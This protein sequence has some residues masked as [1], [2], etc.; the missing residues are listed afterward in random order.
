VRIL[1]RYLLA[2]YLTL[3]VS[4]LCVAALVIAIVEMML[5]FEQMFEQ[6][7]GLRGVA[8][9]L[10]LR[11]A[12][13]YLPY[14][15]PFASFGAGFLCLGIP[16]RAHE[17]VA[18]K[19]GGIAPLRIASPLLAAALA[20]SMLT[21]IANE[22]MVLDAT[23]TRV[24]RDADEDGGGLFQARGSF[25]YHRGTFLYNVRE[26]DRASR[27]LRGVSVFERD[28]A[29]QL[30]RRLEAESAHISED[31]RWHLRNAT[32]RTFDTDDPTAAPRTEHLPE[33]VLA[34]GTQRNL[35]LLD[36][37][38]STLSLFRLREYIRAVKDDG[39]DSTRY[40]AMFHERLADPVSVLLFTLLGI[41]LGLAVEQSRSL[42]VAG[43]QGIALLGLFYAVKTLTS[44]LA[45]SGVTAAVPGPW[46]VV[47]AFGGYAAWRIA[48][49]PS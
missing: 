22:T 34:V 37:D 17:L 32:V 38:A 6:G 29:G 5:N 4:I 12:T 24:G 1:S 16:A 40:R 41:P 28:G 44:M 23:M 20:I 33:T 31:H 21:L 8:T 35:A 25:W 39:R 30:T 46:F 47:G 9:Y 49:A 48:R 43:I 19:T 42:A 2:S 36:A 18:M 27:T 15:V 7:E 11:L 26:A 14:L 10:L 45:D 3:F 13:D